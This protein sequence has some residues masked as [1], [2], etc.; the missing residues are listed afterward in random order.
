MCVSWHMLEDAGNISGIS[1][2]KR[3][4]TCNKPSCRSGTMAGSHGQGSDT[5]TSNC[6]SHRGAL[7]TMSPQPQGNQHGK[8]FK[9]LLTSAVVRT[10]AVYGVVIIRQLV[11][12]E[13][14]DLASNGQETS[15]ARC[16][17]VC[18]NEHIK[19]LASVHRGI[20]RAH[21]AVSAE[22]ETLQP[23]EGM[24][25]L[26]RPHT[27]FGR[28]MRVCSRKRSPQG[29]EPR[30]EGRYNG[31]HVRQLPHELPQRTD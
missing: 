8:T 12:E 19:R 1:N 16:G 23:C 2:I 14:H 3:K 7:P 11:M 13:L 15:H 26:F 4:L 17:C 21:D 25:D 10:L 28:T 5:V 18:S 9:H 22:H 29:L 20:E 30:S 6:K 27:T 31:R 24:V